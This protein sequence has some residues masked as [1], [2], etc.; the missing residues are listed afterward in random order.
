MVSMN[1]IKP[2]DITA[3]IIASV[4]GLSRMM[5]TIAII[6]AR[7]KQKSISSPPRAAMGLPHPGRIIIMQTIV[8]PAIARNV[9]AI[10]PKRIV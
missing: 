3:A 10:F 4:L 7:G 8:R 5:P 6:R 9:T 2:P 1:R